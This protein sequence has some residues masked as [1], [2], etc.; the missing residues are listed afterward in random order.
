VLAAPAFSSSVRNG[1]QVELTWGTRAGKSY[2]VDYKTDLNAAEW[3]P[4]WTNLATG[5]SLTFTNVT[6]NAPQSFYRI[7]TVD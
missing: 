3:T 7:R 4:L 1:D 2:A 5:G 6:T